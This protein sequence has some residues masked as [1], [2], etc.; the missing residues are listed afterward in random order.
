MET[1]KIIVRSY[2]D[3]I[4]WQKSMELSIL[5]YK[6]TDSFPK[7]EMFSL[8]NQIRRAVVS[9][10]SNIAEGWARKGLGEYIQFL[11]IAYGSASEV[12]TQLILSKKLGFGEYQK[13]KNIK[14]VLVEVQKLLYVLI[15]RLKSKA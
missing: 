8:V 3:L 4:A 14:E 9:I 12:E 2:K 11:S 10:P 15:K 1:Q 13:Y 5:V 7:S 6:L